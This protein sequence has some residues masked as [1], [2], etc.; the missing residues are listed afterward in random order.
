MYRI[1]ETVVNGRGVAGVAGSPEWDGIAGAR[2][3]IFVKQFGNFDL[4]N[5][6]FR[7]RCGSRRDSLLLRPPV[8]VRLG[9]E[10]DEF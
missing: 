9:A 2:L 3:L 4:S 7:G 1:V 6:C 8:E 10:L 5:I